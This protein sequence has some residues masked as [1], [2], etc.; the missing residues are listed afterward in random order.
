MR[1]QSID[2]FR[3]FTIALMIFVNACAGVSG[4]PYWMGHLPGNVD[5]FTYVDEVFP[6]FLFAVGLSM[7]LAL[8]R[9]PREIFWKR[10]FLRAGSLIFLGVMM[11]N[12][13]SYDAAA[14]GMPP[15]VF[16]LLFY[17]CAY[18]IWGSP[19]WLKWPRRVAL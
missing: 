13:E 18:A 10:L 17:A 7:P 1:S 16:S 3:G 19:E 15:A 14:T 5:G 11:V 6:A 8:S 4:I 9:Q 2:A 12:M